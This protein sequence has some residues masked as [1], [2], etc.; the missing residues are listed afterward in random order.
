MDTHVS[1]HLHSNRVEDFRLVTGAGKYAADL[2][3]RE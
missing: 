3:E 2:T 1:H